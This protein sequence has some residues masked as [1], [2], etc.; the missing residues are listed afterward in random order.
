MNFRLKLAW[1]LFLLISIGLHSLFASAAKA[2]PQSPEQRV[3]EDV[4]ATTVLLSA[5]EIQQ[6]MASLPDWTTDG[7]TLFY[8]RTF[9]D[10]VSAISFVNTIVEPAEALAHHPDIILR[11]NRLFLQVTTHDA[12]GLTKLDFELAESISQITAP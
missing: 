4:L 8:D 9:E 2:I 12:G 6:R 7:K 5:S 3:Q 10:F 1:T 11:Y